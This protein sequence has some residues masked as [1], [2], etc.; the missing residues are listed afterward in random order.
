MKAKGPG[1]FSIEP[2]GRSEDLHAG[3]L[4][5]RVGGGDSFAS[6]LIYG[7]LNDY[8]DKDTLEYAV[9]ASCLKQTIEFDFNQASEKEVLALAGGN[10]SGR[11]QR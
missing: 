9:A 5:D 8:S 3:Q 11:I 6:G 2:L 7:F 1:A 10:A 4:V